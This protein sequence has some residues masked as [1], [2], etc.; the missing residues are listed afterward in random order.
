MVMIRTWLCTDEIERRKMEIR[1]ELEAQL[2]E[3][4]AT[5][6]KG[7]RHLQELLLAKEARKQVKHP[8]LVY[9]TFNPDDRPAPQQQ[10]GMSAT[11]S[12]AWYE[13]AKGL[14]DDAIVRERNELLDDIEEAMLSLCRETRE[15]RERVA[16]LEA[17]AAVARAVSSGEVAQIIK[18]AKKKGEPYVG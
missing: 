14:I 6:A 11:D 18:P 8:G 2:A 1:Q 13:W 10:T 12:A 4:E 5:Y 17:D 15:L 9:K 3:L 7:E 16:K